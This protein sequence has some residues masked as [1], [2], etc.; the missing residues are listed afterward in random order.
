MNYFIK[1]AKTYATLPEMISFWI[2][3]PIVLVLL[4]IT[5]LNLPI[6]LA[7]ISASLFFLLLVILFVNN[8]RLAR[9]NLEIKVE[10][11]ELSGIVNNLADGIIA[12]DTDFKIL[13]FNKAAELIFDMPAKEVIGRSF[14]PNTS[15][16][17]RSRLLPQ[18]LFPSLAPVAV[19][20]SEPGAAIQIVDLSFEDP[21]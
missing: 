7:Y 19:N 2:F 20:R 1:K 18:A 9:S 4:N 12:Y 13:V 15:R 21:K 6:R 11:N 3:L 16:N 8:L 5:F 10:R 14:S 17:M